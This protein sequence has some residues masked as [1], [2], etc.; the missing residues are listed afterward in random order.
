MIRHGLF[1]EPCR[2]ND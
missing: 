1:K 2:R